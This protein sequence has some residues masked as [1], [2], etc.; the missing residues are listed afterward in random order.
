MEC[1][2]FFLIN[3]VDSM[4]YKI[5]ENDAELI[6]PGDPIENGEYGFLIN[7]IDSPGD[8]GWQP[9]TDAAFSVTDGAL[10]VV[11]SGKII[12]LLSDCI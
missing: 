7:L 2:H 1:T 11:E 9:K 4:F 10:V 8:V 5:D 6:N 12:I 3:R